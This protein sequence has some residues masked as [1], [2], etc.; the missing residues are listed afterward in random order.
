MI[1]VDKDLAKIPI[2]LSV[3]DED[4][5]KVPAK[6]THRK[7]M[8]VI[9]DGS[10]P[11]SDHSCSYDKCYKADDI[12]NALNTLYHGKCAFCETRTEVMHVEHFRPKRGNPGYWHLAGI[13]YC[14]VV[15]LATEIRA[16]DSH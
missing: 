16:T 13:I 14:C 1:K 12:K 10:Y 7:R 6:T 2:S 8:K 3:K 9:N 15:L 4:I 11:P 5:D